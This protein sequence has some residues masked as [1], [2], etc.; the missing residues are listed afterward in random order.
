LW[1]FIQK[2]FSFFV[3]DLLTQKLFVI[4]IFAIAYFSTKNLLSVFISDKLLI[5]VGTLFFI[6]NPFVYP[7]LVQ[8]QFYILYAYALLPFVI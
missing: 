6:L 5:F 2:G 1:I 3:G 8:G 7:R 4:G